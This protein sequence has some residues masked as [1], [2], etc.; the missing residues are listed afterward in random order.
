MLN[1]ADSIKIAE[2]QLG[3]FWD[4]KDAPDAPPRNY[5]V[6]NFGLDSDINASLKNLHEG[7]SKFGKMATP[8]ITW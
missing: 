4:P 5:F 2:K 3:H 1:A 6:P 7:E 8:E